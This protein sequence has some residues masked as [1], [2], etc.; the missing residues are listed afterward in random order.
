M[1]VDKP[2]YCRPRAYELFAAQVPLIHTSRGLMVAAVAIAMHEMKD[3]DPAGVEQQIEHYAQ[4][5]RSR[6]RSDHPEALQ[7]HLHDVLFEEEGFMGN[8]EDYYQSHNSYLPAVLRSKRGLPIT[9]TLLYKL[10][11]ERVGLAVHGVNAPGHF[12]AEVELG[13]ESM[14]IDSFFGGRAYSRH[15]AER[16]VQEVTGAAVPGDELLP[17]ATHRQWLTRMLMN[18]QNVFVQQQRQ[19]ELAA[20]L[21]LRRVLGEE[22]SKK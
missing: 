3:V 16:R 4:N 9:L 20:M 6:V 22:E 11:G 12:L 19:E 15:E 2:T 18:L 5:V 13:R 21:E 17:R 14:Y 8:A 1:S 7:A 10:V